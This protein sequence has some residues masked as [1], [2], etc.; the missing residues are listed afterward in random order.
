MDK[1]K[2]PHSEEH[3]RKISESQKALGDNHWSKRPETRLKRSLA[4]KGRRGCWAGKK[5]DNPEYIKKISEAHKGQHSSPETQFKK[6]KINSHSIVGG[7]NEYRALHKWIVKQL[8]QPS[9]CTECGK[10][11]LNGRQIHWAN[12]SGG[13][14]RELSDWIRLCVKCHYYHDIKRQIRPV[15]TWKK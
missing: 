12:D 1:R 10:S 7:K 6:V 4:M 2:Q 13:Y 8:G 3:T 15:L 11:E 5:R 9:T 14:K